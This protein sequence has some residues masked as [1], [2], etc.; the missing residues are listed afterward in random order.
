MISGSITSGHCFKLY[1]IRG[2]DGGH[3]ISH[4]LRDKSTRAWFYLQ[5]PNTFLNFGYESKE[6]G[7]G[8]AYQVFKCTVPQDKAQDLLK[9]EFMIAQAP[10]Q[11]SL[12]P[13]EE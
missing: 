9:K 10:R 3:K 4:L 5:R 11:H 1:L 13:G 6:L 7:I 2:Q 8:E 12:K